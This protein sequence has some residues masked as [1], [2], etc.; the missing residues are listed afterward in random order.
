MGAGPCETSN[1]C[2]PNVAEAGAADLGAAGPHR[3]ELLA[4][5]SKL[6]VLLPSE[7]RSKDESLSAAQTA[8]ICEVLTALERLPATLD[9]L[10]ES[11]LGLLTQTV[12]DSP[13][14]QIKTITRRLRKSWKEVLRN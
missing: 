14:P 7:G 1:D 2:T 5:A 10:R 6:R 11:Q 8:E 9:D 4:L 12:K 3:A 13:D